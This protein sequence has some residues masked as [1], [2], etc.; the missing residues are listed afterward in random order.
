MGRQCDLISRAA[1]A[2]AGAF[3]R[4]DGEIDFA[5]DDPAND[6]SDRDQQQK[7]NFLPQLEVRHRIRKAEER[8]VGEQLF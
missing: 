7:Q 5:A 1:A 2:L 3:V 4:V 8:S 6:D